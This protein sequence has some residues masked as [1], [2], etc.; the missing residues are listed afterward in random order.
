MQAKS[1]FVQ[2]NINTLPHYFV[3]G[4]IRPVSLIERREEDLQNIYPNHILLSQ[5]KWD[6]SSD[7]SIEVI[8]NDS[9]MKQLETLGS[10]YFLYTS[11]IP[12]SRIKNIYIINK[13]KADTVTWNIENGAAYV[14]KNKIRIAQKLTEEIAEIPRETKANLVIDVSILKQNYIKFNRLMGGFAFMR[15]SLADINDVNINYPLNYISTFSFFN[16]SIRRELERI[17][18]NANFYLQSIF[19]GESNIF[20]YIAKEINDSVLE[21][22]AKKENILLKSKFGTYDLNSLPKDSSIYKLIIL[23]T[24]GK[25]GSKSI[26][27]LISVLYEDLGDKYKEEI[28]LVFGLHSGYEALRNFYRINKKEVKVKF[29]LSTKIDYYIIES[30]YQYTFNNKTISEGFDYINSIM[31]SEINTPIP[32]GY[33]NYKILNTNIV[34]KK[35]DY[36][37]HLEGLVNDLAIEISDW[38]PKHIV[39]IKIE[40]ISELLNAKLK[41]KF[42]ALVNEI[43]IDLGNNYQIKIKEEASKPIELNPSIT[44]DFQN[45]NPEVQNPVKS[46]ETLEKPNVK[47]FSNP[48]V[49][50]KVEE[51][52]K[53]SLQNID[54]EKEL[55]KNIDNTDNIIPILLNKEELSKKSTPELIK[56]AKQ[57]GIKVSSKAKKEV[58]LEKILTEQISGK[59]DLE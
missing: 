14:P 21:D 4:C 15:T 25:S 34:T 50:N 49:V 44:N 52:F 36:V 37:E 51:E 53:P 12:I 24:Y 42:D 59:L 20:A 1:F 23:Y 2:I 43:K 32:I 13:E 27:D 16:K 35:K 29:D 7:C 17:D 5:K 47:E 41:K 33:K 58:I 57:K 11:I 10:D 45:L 22:L 9:E 48:I 54:T 38:F 56:Y 30:L 18:S 28:A 46:S 26:E 19:T 3:G 55:I 31:P 39:K 6:N 8:L 40:A